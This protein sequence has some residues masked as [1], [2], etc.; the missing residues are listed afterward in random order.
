ME[1][2]LVTSLVYKRKKARSQIVKKLLTKM[3]NLSGADIPSEVVIGDDIEFCHNCLG[4]VIYCNTT[5][6]DNVRIYQ[7]VTIGQA[8]LFSEQPASF[9]IKEGAILCA[10]AKIL[11]K[12]QLTVGRNTI[13]AANAVLLSSTGDNEVWA[14]IPAKKIKDR[15]RIR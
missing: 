12:G 8:D 4:S 13:I 1:K 14:G 7:N 9:C 11:G 10:G 3:I 5:I 2:N 15:E 6:E